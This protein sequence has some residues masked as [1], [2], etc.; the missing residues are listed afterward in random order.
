MQ[1]RYQVAI[2]G[3]LTECIAQHHDIENTQD[4]SQQRS[5]GG[6]NY[7]SIFHILDG[8]DELVASSSSLQDQ[9]AIFKT[10]SKFPLL[11]YVNESMSYFVSAKLRSAKVNL[12]TRIHHTCYVPSNI[13]KAYQKSFHIIPLHPL[14]FNLLG[15]EWK[16]IL[17]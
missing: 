14:D 1:Q 3:F 10:V 4:V 12:P 5:H 17:S 16:I 6:P 15:L 2:G 7:N 13:Y 9:I 11:N 8:L